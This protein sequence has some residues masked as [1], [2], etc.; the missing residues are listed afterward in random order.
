MVNLNGF[1]GFQY[2]CSKYKYKIKVKEIVPSYSVYDKEYK[3]DVENDIKELENQEQLSESLRKLK[4]SSTKKEPYILSIKQLSSGYSLQIMSLIFVSLISAVGADD[5]CECKSSCRCQ[6]RVYGVPSGPW[7]DCSS[8]SDFCKSGAWTGGAIAGITI[9]A[10]CGLCGC[11]YCILRCRGNIKDN[12]N[13]TQVTTVDI[14]PRTQDQE[15]QCRVSTVHR[16][17]PEIDRQ[18]RDY[19]DDN[20]L[21]YPNLPGS[22]QSARHNLTLNAQENPSSPPH[23]TTPTRRN[24]L[25]RC[26]F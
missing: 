21:V 2:N 12:T 8:G 26:S 5:D 25:R 10:I 7:F 3:V 24:S 9:G 13:N 20:N 19:C 22:Y 18:N 23:L 16:I 17:Q 11:I 14:N 6:E 15:L 1:V 4:I